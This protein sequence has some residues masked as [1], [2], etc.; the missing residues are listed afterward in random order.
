MKRMMKHYR[1]TTILAVCLAVLLSSCSSDDDGGSD[2]PAS[3]SQY[4]QAEWYSPDAER[5][6]SFAYMH[7]AGVVYQNMSTFPETAETFSGRWTY[8]SGGV[9]DMNIL[10]D[11]SLKGGTEAYNVLQC[12]DTTLRLRHT[13][14]GMTLDFYKIVESYKGRIGDRF[15]IEYVKNH[16][17]FASATYTSSNAGIA[18]V[19]SDGRVIVKGGGLAFITVSSSAGKVMLKVDGGQRV[20][21]YTAEIAETIDQVMARHGEPDKTA[22]FETG[23]PAIIYNTAP[24]II[25]SAV[26]Q[27]AYVY[28]AQTREISYMEVQYS[29]AANQWFLND[30][31]YLIREFYLYLNNEGYYAPS[32]ILS[33][34]HYF[35]A[36][37]KAAKANGF[38]I[39]NRDFY[40]QHGHY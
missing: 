28:D 31:D 11:N 10:Y 2:F 7:V 14:L 37:V 15:D 33:E 5:Y 29:S 32:Q 23:L 8:S 19:D 25:D 38:A 1:I 21:G 35:I 4:I 17:D 9:L 34:N 18:D 36:V 30:E 39:Y 20:D 40:A 22:T 13:L 6:M 24:K 12:D 27:T 3:V 26:G 16:P